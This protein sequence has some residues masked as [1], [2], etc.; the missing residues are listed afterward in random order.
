MLSPAHV[1]A[2]RGA[3]DLTQAAL[4]ARAGLTSQT[5]AAFERG[6]VV[7]SPTLAAIY[8]ALESS[9]IAVTDSG[10]TWTQR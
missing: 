4:A 1:R 7:K 9:G 8:S 2:A 10:I 5:I 3:L 6:E